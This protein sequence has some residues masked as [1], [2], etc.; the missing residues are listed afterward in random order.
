[1]K[2]LP[3]RGVALSHRALTRH[4]SRELERQLEGFRAL[5]GRDPSHLDSH[6]HRHTW[7][8]VQPLF[9][10]MARNLGVP[11]RRTKLGIPFCGSFYGHDGRGRPDHDAITPEALIE[12]LEGLEPGATE[13]GCHPG[14]AFDLDSW[15]RMEREQEVRSLCD[16]R[17]RATVTRLG[18][19]LCTFAEV[20]PVTA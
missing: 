10:R 6:Q 5:L 4:V 11:L 17:V 18:V 12:L 14:Y 9:K 15:Y 8:L 13:L 20:P 7:P 2:R 19:R 16:P 3:G 1:V